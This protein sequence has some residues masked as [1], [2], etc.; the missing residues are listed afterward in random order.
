M[1]TPGDQS[2]LSPEATA[3]I[4]ELQSVITDSQRRADKASDDD[5]REALQL[6]VAALGL[7]IA[8]LRRGLSEDAP[9]DPKREED[10]EA[11]PKPN[12]EQLREADSLIQRAMLEK[13]RGNRQA[14]ADL[15][16][17]ASEVAPGAPTVLE[18]LGDDC[19]ERKLF[20]QA[21]AAYKQAHL[22]DPS[23]ASIERK[24]AQTSMAGFSNLSFEDRLRV[25][26]SDNPFIQAG[27]SYASPKVATLLSVLFPGLGQF[28][29]G[30]TRKGVIIFALCISGAVL[31]AILSRTNHGARTL[32]MAAYF[33]LMIAIGA[34]IA[35]VI[36]ASM[37]SR[38]KA[39]PQGPSRPVP[40]ANL[41]FE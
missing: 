39:K 17:Q 28:V 25:S 32:P 13:R 41:P 34:W 14:A 23:N 3:R 2:P 19:L 18:V 40:P 6:Q 16:K 12:E 33:P 5:I 21:H 38:G 15:M 22:A 7:K 37:N 36:D 29:L 24:Y 26:Q 8:R 1:S 20:E 11:P 31:F 30:Q 35:G 9:V 27:E 4:R 10:M